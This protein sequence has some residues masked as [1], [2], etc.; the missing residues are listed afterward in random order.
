MKVQAIRECPNQLPG[1][2]FE[3]PEALGRVFIAIGAARE[4]SSEPDADKPIR[5]QYRRRD[6]IAQNS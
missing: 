3:V 5:R 2:I 4:V 6:L 1:S